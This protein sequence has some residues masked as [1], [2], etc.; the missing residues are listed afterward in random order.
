[1]REYLEIVNT[2]VSFLKLLYE[3]MRNDTKDQEERAREFMSSLK[4][5]RYNERSS[6]EVKAGIS[7]AYFEQFVCCVGCLKC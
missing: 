6:C 2:S 5:D 1:M 4:F 3:K 7:I